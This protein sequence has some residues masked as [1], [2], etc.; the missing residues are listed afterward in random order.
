MTLGTW[1]TAGQIVARVHA[2]DRA[3]ALAGEA[4]V[5]AALQVGAGNVPAPL[6]VLYSVTTETKQ[7][8]KIRV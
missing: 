7:A 8:V 3:S 4:E 1:V 2:H 6:L 5:L